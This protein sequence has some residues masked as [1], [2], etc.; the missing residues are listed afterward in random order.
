LPVD[1]PAAYDILASMAEPL[2]YLDTEATAVR[3]QQ[4][5]KLVTAL[6]DS[7]Y[8]VDSSRVPKA[9]VSKAV[10]I[11]CK[12]TGD[13]PQAVCFPGKVIGKISA[14]DR[15]YVITQVVGA[16]DVSVALVC[17]A[18]KYNLKG[19]YLFAGVV[20]G[21]L[22]TEDSAQKITFV[23]PAIVMWPPSATHWITDYG[24]TFATTSTPKG[25]FITTQ[26]LLD[27]A[28]EA[29]WGN[30]KQGKPGGYITLP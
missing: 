4:A 24:A 12:P 9:T 26:R 27:A 15:D 6:Y 14:G 22:T 20:G 30:L 17:K 5:T 7:I 8:A 25:L 23:W 29:D 2:V 1:I 13:T 11:L 3:P 16:P 21:R 28:A 18:A 19:S 10:D